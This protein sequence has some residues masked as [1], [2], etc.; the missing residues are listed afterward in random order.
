MVFYYRLSPPS[1]WEWVEGLKVITIN[2]YLLPQ[3]RMESI[4]KQKSLLAHELSD[5]RWNSLKSHLT[6][7]WINFKG[8]RDSSI[9][10]QFKWFRFR[11]CPFNQSNK[12]LILLS[13]TDWT[14]FERKAKKKP[15]IN[16]IIRRNYSRIDKSYASQTLYFNFFKFKKNHS[17]ELNVRYF[18]NSANFFH[19]WSAI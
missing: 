5:F 17:C 9:F 11:E 18:E 14:K 3:L 10:H 7:D 16:T 13:L 6:F 1:H 12:E 4:E 8:N 15:I 19:C 2:T